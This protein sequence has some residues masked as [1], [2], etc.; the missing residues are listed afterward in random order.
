MDQYILK[1]NILNLRND[2]QEYLAMNNGDA[3]T[4]TLYKALNNY[5]QEKNIANE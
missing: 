4:Q 1:Q 2:L 3:A 5:M